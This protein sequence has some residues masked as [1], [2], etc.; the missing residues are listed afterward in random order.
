MSRPFRYQSNAAAE[1]SAIL[2]YLE[3]RTTI[4]A[5]NW[6]DEYEKTISRICEFPEQFP[7]A[8]E[9]REL[10][11]PVQNATVRTRFGHPYRI[12]FVERDGEIVILSVRGPG[13]TDFKLR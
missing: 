10:S 3:Q 6:L 11:M 12:I 13:Q 7:V 9:S 8:P 2:D 5:I 4:G 1:L